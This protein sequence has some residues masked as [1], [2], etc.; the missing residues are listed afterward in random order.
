M[1]EDVFLVLAMITDTFFVS[2]S[3]AGEKIKIPVMSAV[4][5]SFVSSCVLA[6]SLFFSKSVSNFFPQEYCRIIGAVTLGLIGAV[7]LC[8]SSLKAVLKKHSGNGKVSFSCFDIGFVISVYLDETKADSDCSKVL[9]TKESLALALALS[10]DSLSGGIAAGISGSN[11]IG[12]ALMSFL[13]GLF[14]VAVGGILGNRIK[15]G[16]RD[17]SWISGI[18]LVG[19][20]VIKLFN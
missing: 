12:T 6:V 17:F 1:T 14:A 19:L 10:V 3:Y 11:I 16:N 13:L 15:K 18:F 20:A 9:S 8:Q 4:V 2:L 5:I 7:Q